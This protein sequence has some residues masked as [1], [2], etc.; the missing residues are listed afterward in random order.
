MPAR[1]STMRASTT[2]RL[3]SILLLW[4]CSF[5]TYAELVWNGRTTSPPFD[6]LSVNAPSYSVIIGE[7]TAI[8]EADPTVG[9]CSEVGAPHDVNTSGAVGATV[10]GC[11]GGTYIADASCTGA[12]ETLVYD[13]PL[14]YHCYDPNPPLPECTAGD[15]VDITYGEFFANNESELNIDVQTPLCRASCELVINNTSLYRSSQG[16]NCIINAGK[17]VCD[18]PPGYTITFNA[19]NTGNNCTTETPPATC[20]TCKATTNTTDQPL[21]SPITSTD[22]PG[23]QTTTSTESTD[24]GDGT[25]TKTETTTQPD[26]TKTTKS[27]VINNTTGDVISSVTNNSGDSNVDT[28]T[29]TITIPTKGTFD[30]SQA[31]AD[32][33]AA[34]AEFGQVFDQAKTNV[35]NAISLTLS[36]GG[37]LSN[38]TVVIFGKTIDWSPATVFSRWPLIGSIIVFFASVY[39]FIILLRA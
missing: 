27:T 35:S 8:H 22:S 9:P 13:G 20:P 4:L 11:A 18:T 37:A 29:P 12:E 6:T 5:S 16:K 21:P 38:A 19:A 15:T 32:L 7:Y 36:D 33:T 39:A 1:S 30:L 28:E 24:N 31:Q 17:Q 25:T 14:A 10:T 26:G 3:L 34:K 23:P 2:T